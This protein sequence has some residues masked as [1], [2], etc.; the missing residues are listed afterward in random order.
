[1]N[2]AQE[3]LSYF[4]EAGIGKYVTGAIKKDTQRGVDKAKL[5]TTKA[6][7]YHSVAQATDKAVQKYGAHK[8][9]IKDTRKEIA[10]QARQD[11]Y[12]KVKSKF[13]RS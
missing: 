11:A 7:G 3:I 2:R 13:S 5:A 6:Q 4:N 9:K 8:Q 12:S 1:M 10:R